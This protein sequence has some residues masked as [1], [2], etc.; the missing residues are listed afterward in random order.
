MKSIVSA[1]LRF[2]A[3]H[4]CLGWVNSSPIALANFTG[5]FGGKPDIF[6]WNVRSWSHSRRGADMAGTGKS[7]QN[8]SFGSQ[9]SAAVAANSR[10]ALVNENGGI[11][12][13]WSVQS[14]C[15]TATPLV[16]LAR[17][18][19]T[20]GVAPYLFTRADESP[21]FREIRAS[22]SEEIGVHPHDPRRRG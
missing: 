11:D 14:R 19:G 18:A 15:P 16:F 4:E 2:S 5:S 21:R 9:W 3:A 17:T 6:W 7:S 8:R 22:L 20:R 12:P 10:A 13:R 1:A